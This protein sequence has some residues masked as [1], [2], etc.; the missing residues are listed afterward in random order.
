MK[1]LK[2][3]VA[4][5]VSEVSSPTV[6]VPPAYCPEE[7]GLLAK[8]VQT[9]CAHLESSA[10]LANLKTCLSHLSGSE[11]EAISHLIGKYPSLYADVPSQ[12]TVLCHDIDV[13]NSQPIKQHPYR[14]NPKKRNL[15]KS[16][17]Q[18]LLDH[19]LAMPSQRPWSSS[20]ILV[21]KSDSTFRFCTDYRKLNAV[22]KPDSFPLERMEDCVDRASSARCHKIRLANLL[23]VL[24]SSINTSCF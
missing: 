14:V 15:I 22:T 8:D 4:R 11:F 16:E 7:D 24:A 23:R 21:P 5:D 12:T 10:V 13:G 18:Y 9:L 6:V 2:A 1:K 3:Y 20:C 19:G 17:V